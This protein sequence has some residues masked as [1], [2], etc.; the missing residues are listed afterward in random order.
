MSFEFIH[1]YIDRKRKTSLF[2][3]VY[4]SIRDHILTGTLAPE[5]RLP[6]TRR[7]AMELNI[8]RNVVMEAYDQLHAEGYIESRQGSYTQV[9]ADTR[10]PGYQLQTAA[11]RFQK[12][13]DAEYDIDF[14]TGIPDLKLFPKTL[15]GT[16]L[17][18]AA[19]QTR[20]SD[21]SYD[22]PEGHVEFREVL[23]DYLF[24]VK[25]IMANPDQIVITS[26]ATQ[27][28]SLV[29]GI[30]YTDPCDAV[31]EDPGGFGVMKILESAGYKLNPADTGP[32]G[33]ILPGIHLTPQTKMVYITPSHQ[34][35]MGSILPAAGRIE[36]LCLIQDKDIYIVEDDYDSEFR[37][38][39]P[40]L[41]P[42]K[43]LDPEKVIYIG[44]FSKVLSPALRIGY[45]VLPLSL[46]EKF[47][48]KKL[49]SDA[50]SPAIEQI[51]L[52]NFIKD[53]LFEKHVYKMKKIYK[54][55]RDVLINVLTDEFGDTIRIYGEN[56]GLHVVVE[57]L[58]RTLPVN[59]RFEVCHN[60]IFIHSVQKHALQKGRQTNKLI[61]GYG[62]LTEHDIIFGI[63]KLNK[64]R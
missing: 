47:K 14:R 44:S 32:R 5:T 33:I 13:K 10:Y 55:K 4:E 35:P 15:W 9:A 51:A 39:G 63:R 2:R 25:G 56:A 42:V 37:Y 6:P 36:L 7:L 57:F 40:P 1:I 38:D 23:S 64:F 48:Q 24:R 27:A 16:Y 21:L 62:N 26:G 61:F 52:K 53:G 58:D 41:H 8:S 29:A 12:K 18:K 22:A 31:I 34:F 46:A 19:V 60:K 45:A 17:K 20:D 3:Q 43:A 28:L 11:G 54:R 50:Q 59:S 49:F 30:L